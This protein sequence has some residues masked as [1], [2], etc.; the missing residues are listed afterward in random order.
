VSGWAV[1]GHEGLV[2]T[3]RSLAAVTATAAESQP[4]T[5]RAK[6]AFISRLPSHLI[7][8]YL[9][10]FRL[11]RVRCEATRFAVAATNQLQYNTVQNSYGTG[12]ERM[13][14]AVW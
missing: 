11:N 9:S 7:S 3:V 8:S 10:S 4:S 13:G 5:T 12:G 2:A 1:Q 6:P 14:G